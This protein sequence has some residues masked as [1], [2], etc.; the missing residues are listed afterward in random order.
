MKLVD[1]LLTLIKEDVARNKVEDAIERHRM[2]R[3]YYAGDKT[4]ARGW[5]F[6]EPYVYG[7]SFADNRVIRAYQL[8]GVTDTE[9]PGWKTF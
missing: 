1:S 7:I 4:V 6:I 5:R 3:I 2:V 9:S 8:N